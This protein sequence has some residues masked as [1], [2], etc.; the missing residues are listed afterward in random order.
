MMYILS[1]EKEDVVYRFTHLAG[2]DKIVIHRKPFHHTTKNAIWFSY[3][4][5]ENGEFDRPRELW[6]E[7]ISN[8]YERTT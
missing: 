2:S 4:K 5:Y 1:N 6:E 3:S 8:G 7:L